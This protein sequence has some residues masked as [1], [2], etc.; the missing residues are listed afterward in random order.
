[1]KETQKSICYLTTESKDWV[2]NSAF[3]ERMKKWSIEVVYV[4]KPIYR[5]CMQQV[6]ELYGGKPSIF[7]QGGHVTI[8]G[9]EGEENGA[10]EMA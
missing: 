8:R 10:G 3:M 2:A 6:K 9:Q 5:G 1:M 7:D 4:T